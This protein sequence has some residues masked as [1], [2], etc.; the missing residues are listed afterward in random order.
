MGQWHTLLLCTAD[1]IDF[2]DEWGRGK[3][4]AWLPR[5]SFHK[6]AKLYSKSSDLDVMVK[7][8]NPTCARLVP[9]IE[10]TMTS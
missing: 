7:D 6:H 3:G 4:G 1:R 9:P 10:R 2:R 5:Y 8:K